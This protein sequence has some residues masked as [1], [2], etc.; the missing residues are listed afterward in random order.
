MNQFTMATSKRRINISLPK[1]V[2]KVLK[3]LAKRD[4]VPEATKAIHLIKL[5]IEIEEDRIWNKI[6]E[7]RDTD[8][9]E[10]VSHEKAWS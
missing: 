6:A 9:A 4:D 1:D 10:F 8:D 7:E 3:L 5:A 2:E